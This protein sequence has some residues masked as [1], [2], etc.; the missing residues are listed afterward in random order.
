M[1]LY[2][3]QDCCSIHILPKQKHVNLSTTNNTFLPKDTMKN[4]DMV[5]A[6]LDFKQD[7]FLNVTVPH[8]R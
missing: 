4:V 2:I 5:K 7:Q 3:S 6:T 1:L 8:V